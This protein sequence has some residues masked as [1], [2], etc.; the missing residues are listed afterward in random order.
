[1]GYNTQREQISNFNRAVTENTPVSKSAARDPSID[2]HYQKIQRLIGLNLQNERDRRKQ[3]KSQEKVQS[4]H[5]TN[6]LGQRL[7]E[8]VHAY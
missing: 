4:N 6:Q 1:M 8:Q 5:L 2:G 3:F 7:I